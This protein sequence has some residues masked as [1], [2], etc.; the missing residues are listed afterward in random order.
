MSRPN[1]LRWVLHYKVSAP[2]TVANPIDLSSC[3]GDLHIVNGNDDKAFVSVDGD[4]ASNPGDKVLPG[5]TKS[6][7]AEFSISRASVGKDFYLESMC[8]DSVSGEEIACHQG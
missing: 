5:A 1:D 7:D 3:P 6:G 4:Y 2:A 8:G